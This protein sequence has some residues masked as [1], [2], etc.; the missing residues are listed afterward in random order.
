MEQKIG[1]LNYKP[2][3]TR[4]VVLIIEAVD[5]KLT[6]LMI[7]VDTVVSQLFKCSAPC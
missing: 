3:L 1:W 5:M 2:R 4:G 6:A 7:P